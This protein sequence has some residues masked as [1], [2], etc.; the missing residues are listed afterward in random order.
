MPGT[1]ARSPSLSLGGDFQARNYKFYTYGSGW[2][3]GGNFAASPTETTLNTDTS[4]QPESTQNIGNL[5]HI[6]NVSTESDTI[7]NTIRFFGGRSKGAT[8]SQ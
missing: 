6:K 3:G 2:P 1:A 7:V 4:A 5:C 8:R